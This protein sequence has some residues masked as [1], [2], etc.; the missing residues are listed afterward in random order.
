MPLTVEQKKE[1]RSTHGANEQD[2]GSTVVQIAQL[3]TRINHLTEHLKTNKKDFACIRGLLMLVSN[4]R[5][6]LKYY[7]RKNTPE[8][9]QALLETFN[10]RK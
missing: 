9:Y 7:R 3:T 1:L 2:T 4:R 8:A 5:R 6:L 10:L